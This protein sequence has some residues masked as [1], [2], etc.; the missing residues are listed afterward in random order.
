M[1]RVAP[2]AQLAPKASLEQRRSL[3]CVL[4]VVAGAIVD[5]GTASERAKAWRERVKKEEQNV[6]PS[7][8]QV[9]VGVKKER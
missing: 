6:S 1:H 2:T 7:S 4:V 8:E 9:L 5:V 3:Y